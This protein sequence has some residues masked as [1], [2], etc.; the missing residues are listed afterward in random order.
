MSRVL[1]ARVV[2]SSSAHAALDHDVV[3]RHGRARQ[4]TLENENL[5]LT[6]EAARIAVSNRIE[7]CLERAAKVL[8]GFVARLGHPPCS[9]TYAAARATSDSPNRPRSNPS[10]SA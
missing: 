3:V 4:K 7:P 9:R 8:F 2:R 5:A 10:R 6:D 1:R